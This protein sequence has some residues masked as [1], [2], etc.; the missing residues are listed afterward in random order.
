MYKKYNM[1]QLNLPLFTDILFEENDIVFFVNDIVESIPD[2]TFNDF[3][4]KFGASSYHPK[5]M[6]KIILFSYTQSIFSGRRI[7]SALHD[8][9]RLMWL[10]QG[11]KPSYRTINRFRVNP[12]LASILEELFIQFRYQL[13]DQ[14]LIDENVLYI[15]GT[16]LE[17]NANKYTFVWKKNTERYNNQTI[18]KSKEMYYK[19]I[20][21]NI[22]PEILEDEGDEITLEHLK[23]MENAAE[24][25]VEELNTQITNTE[26]GS[27][28]KIIRSERTRINKYSKT[29]KNCIEKKIKY[30]E[31]FEKHGDR[32]SHS[33]TD[34]DATFMRMKDDHMKNGQLKPAYNVQV[35]TSNQYIMAFDVFPNPTDTRTLIPFLENCKKKL[36]DLPNI[37][38]ADAGY[39]SEYNYET[40]ANN[41]DITTLIPYGMMRKEESNSFKKQKFN[42]INWDFNILEDYYICP[43]NKKLNFLK[44]TYRTDEYGF[45][46]DFEVYKCDDCLDCPLKS[47]CIKGN[48]EFKIISK[49]MNWEQH[50]FNIKEKLSEQENA[51]Y[52]SQRKIDVEPSFGNLKAN[53]GFTRFSVRGKQKVYNELGI[54]LMA[55][56]IRKYTARRA[57]SYLI[58][59]K[60]KNTTLI[61]NKKWCSNHLIDLFMTRPLYFIVGQ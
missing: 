57:D 11:Q 6:L 61:L 44:H 9:L 39:G 26:S 22:I 7:S 58:N 50:K 43:N 53:L 14:G 33:K 28:R 27:E 55:T 60:M 48:S 46:R 42:T 31:E 32:N 45:R 47:Q 10:S 16:K 24:K 29:L 19:L 23:K 40:L 18:A 54:V 13:V 41:F 35:A 5:M 36:N 4:S 2:N 49:N 21:E 59:E 56:N 30:E 25:K 37:I 38:V 52:Y 3:D 51:S 34:K 17:A 20:A 12:K 8:S 15:D 1:Q